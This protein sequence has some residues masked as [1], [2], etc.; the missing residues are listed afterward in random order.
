MTAGAVLA[1]AIFVGAT[2]GSTL[3][4]AADVKFGGQFLTRWE[5]RNQDW[6]NDSDVTDFIGQRTRLN[7]NVNMDDRTSAFIQLQSNRIWGNPTSRTGLAVP[8]DNDASVGIHQAYFT[9]K[10]FFDLPVDLQVGR[11]EVVLDGHRLFGN[12]FWT[13]GASTHDA[14]RVSHSEGNHTLMYVYS[15]DTESGG[16][17][18]AAEQ[19]IHIFYGQLRKVLGGAFSA[20]Y[21]YVNNDLADTDGALVT[22]GTAVPVN[23]VPTVS[24]AGVNF[25]GDTETD[26]DIHTIGFRQAGTLKSL[27]DLI[28]RMEFYYQFGDFACS[29]AACAGGQTG[30][31]DRDA[32]M[33]GARLGKQF[34]NFWWK[35]KITLWYDYLSGDD[36]RNDGDHGAFN[37]LADTGHK[38][39][40][41]QDV[42]LG[43]G[44]SGVAGTGTSHLGLQD[45]ALKLQVSPMKKLTVKADFHVF[46]TAEDVDSTVN[47]AGSGVSLTSVNGIDSDDSHLGEEIDLTVKYA[48]NPYVS[49]LVGYSHFFADELLGAVQGRVTTD[50]GGSGGAVSQTFVS[51]DDDQDWAYVMFNMKF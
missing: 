1:T 23:G 29:A 38:F 49:I 20:Y 43:V 44:G 8:N 27:W 28:Y 34:K 45:L 51:G 15:L 11:Q 6:L 4:F 21:A 41:L 10:K 47:A 37:T 19:D 32:F 33:V 12:T 7:A 17:E 22:T 26:G 39:Y 50:D 46:W 40:G 25:T 5:V 35:P 16:I 36:D 9:L 13:F 31:L 3:A 48:Y 2:L 42:F 18:D 30:S 24:N 14:V